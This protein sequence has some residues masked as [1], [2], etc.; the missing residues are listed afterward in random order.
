MNKYEL[1]SQ[2]ARDKF[3]YQDA[4]HK[5]FGS[6]AINLS[7]FSGALLATATVLLRLSGESAA[8]SQPSV[9]LFVTVGVLFLLT[10]GSGLFNLLPRGW[11]HNP[12]L[13]ELAEHLPNY[14][15]QGIIDWVG[16]EYRRSVTSNQPRLDQ[17]AITLQV[18]IVLLILQGC[19]LAALAFVLL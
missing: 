3:Q 18:T 19:A 7:V 8:L 2:V 4:L 15:D 12:T 11:R 5:D 1:Y 10:A 16:D 14:Q 17:M 9:C 6:K 13:E